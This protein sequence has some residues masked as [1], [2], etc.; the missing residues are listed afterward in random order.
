M[1]VTRKVLK[2]SDK[3]DIPA[4]GDT[5]KIE[6]TGWLF[7]PTQPGNKGKQFDTSVNR[8]DFETL[9]GAGKVIQGWET[10]VVQMS[11]GEKSELTITS[12]YAY[13]DK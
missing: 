13:G 9:I 10:A 5:V 8:G 7:D 3:K 12:D 11:L 2:A 1:G 4:E 6:Y